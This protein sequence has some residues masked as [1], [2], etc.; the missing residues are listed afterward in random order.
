MALAL[1]IGVLSLLGGVYNL[2]TIGGPAWM[3]IE[4]PL[5]LVAAWGAGAIE[6]RRRAP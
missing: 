2:A 3:W 1:V 4:A 5:Y 6:V